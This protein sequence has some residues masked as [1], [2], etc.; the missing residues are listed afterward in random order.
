MS[1]SWYAVKNVTHDAAEISIYDEIGLWGISA[2]TFIAE[3]RG[4][5][6]RHVTIR[7]NSPGGEIF[8]GNAIYNALR[9]HAGGVTVAID[10]LAA[11]M[12]TVIAMA[13]EKRTMAENGMFMI[14]NPWSLSAGESKD[15]RRQ[16]DLL[17]DL[18]ANIVSAYAGR[19]GM[20]RNELS[21]MMDAETWLT[22]KEAKR[23]G[24]I[25][26][27]TEPMKMA[28]K[29]SGS[30]LARFDKTPDVMAANALSKFLATIAKNF[31]IEGEEHT[32][33]SILAALKD[34]PGMKAQLETA[35]GEIVTLKDSV[36][37]KDLEITGYADKISE[38]VN[39]IAA[40]DKSIVDLTVERDTFKNDLTTRTTERD[41]LKKSLGI[42]AAEVVPPINPNPDATSDGAAAIYAKFEA[43]K[44][45]EASAFYAKHQ[46]V[47]SKFINKAPKTDA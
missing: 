3:L 32:E 36:K 30:L 19:T 41:N 45:E 23:H 35:Q 4:L 29:F 14:H 18:K 34:Y 10:S 38:H 6:D 26:D 40:R 15:F 28:A 33:D 27:I 12:A 13:G 17:D 7:I 16:A 8:E 24:F 20:D 47:L 9:R 5:G 11:S 42:A 46:E 1:A 25:T 43:L 37:A 44:G 21:E 39:T 2:K 22:A 31:S